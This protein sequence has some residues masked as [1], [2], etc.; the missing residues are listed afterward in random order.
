M[1]S[2]HAIPIQPK[3]KSISPKTPTGTTY[4]KT[5]T[6]VVA[7]KMTVSPKLTVCPKKKEIKTLGKQGSTRAFPGSP[8]TPEGCPTFVV[9]VV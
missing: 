8:L 2:H 9:A 6:P 5:Q 7:L 4:P 3:E 1:E